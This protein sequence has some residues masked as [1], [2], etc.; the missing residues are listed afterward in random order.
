MVRA[1]LILVGEFVGLLHV[2][3][4]LIHLRNSTTVIS[5][6][7][8]IFDAKGND[9]PFAGSYWGNCK[10]RTRQTS[11][12]PKCTVA[13]VLALSSVGPSACLGEVCTGQFMWP[14][15]L[16]NEQNQHNPFTDEE[17]GLMRTDTSTRIPVYWESLITW[18][19][20]L[21]D[22]N[23]KFCI[24]FWQAGFLISSYN[25]LNALVHTIV[26]NNNGLHCDILFTCIIPY[27]GHIP[28]PHYSCWS[29]SCFPWRRP[30]VKK[31][32]L[33]NCIPF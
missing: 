7:P 1:E 10:K 20:M 31:G 26:Q 29:P 9:L 8:N 16:P 27:F 30:T 17:T 23:S 28:L 13:T 5:W 18:P 12:W 4:S 32:R 14:E 19:E 15:C 22:L 24:T 21:P 25:T 6:L 2:S 3:V 11:L 33:K